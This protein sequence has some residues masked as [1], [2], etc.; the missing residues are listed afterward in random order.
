MAVIQE[1]NDVLVLEVVIEHESAFF[2][3]GPICERGKCYHFARLA[4]I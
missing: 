4:I 3:V 1:K 2:I